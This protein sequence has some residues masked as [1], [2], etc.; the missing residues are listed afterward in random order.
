MPNTPRKPPKGW[1]WSDEAAEYLGVHVVTLYRWRRD[2]VG[3]KGK[4]VGLRRYA[5]KISTLE[6]WMNSDHADASHATAA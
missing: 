3:P 1:L 6:A 5:Y 4:Q 2:D